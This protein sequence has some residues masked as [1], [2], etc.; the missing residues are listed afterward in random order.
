MARIEI[1]ANRISQLPIIRRNDVLPARRIRLTGPQWL[2]SDVF[3]DAG[4]GG[5]EVVEQGGPAV[6]QPHESSVGHAVPVEQVGDAVG[7]GCLGSR[8]T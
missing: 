1:M 4:E 5:G 7:G 6:A 2:G 8:G 3:A